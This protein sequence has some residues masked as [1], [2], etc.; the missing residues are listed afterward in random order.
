MVEDTP[1]FPRFPSRRRPGV[2]ATRDTAYARFVGWM[3]IVLPV[4]ALVLLVLVLTWPKLV[5]KQG[6]EVPPLPL[7]TNDDTDDARAHHLSISGFDKHDRPFTITAR[8]AIQEDP[9]GDT[10]ILEAPSADITLEGGAWLAAKA[11]SGHLNRKTELLQLSGS[12][13]LFHDQ[14]FEL[15]TE[16]ANVDLQNGVA[17][18]DTPVE[19]SGPQGELHAE[20]LEVLDRG[21]RVI[22]TG[23]SRV[24]FYRGAP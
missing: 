3:K 21:E 23:R 14:G 6:T 15:R 13:D 24:V 7:A 12:V 20:G 9:G 19:G 22:F 18:S 1:R 11:D 8:Q 2:A 4:S 16:A 5:L 10:V 17:W